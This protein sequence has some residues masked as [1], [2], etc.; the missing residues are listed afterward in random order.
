MYITINRCMFPPWLAHIGKFMTVVVSAPCL[1]LR[2]ERIMIII[3]CKYVRSME[4]PR[5]GIFS[6][7][8]DSQRARRKT[9][10]TRHEFH[11]TLKQYGWVVVRGVEG[12]MLCS[13]EP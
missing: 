13:L 10:M 11:V 5:G 2:V 6:D 7:P 12:T 3:V 8:Q 1:S 4:G 9:F